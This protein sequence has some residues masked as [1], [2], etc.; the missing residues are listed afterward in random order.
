L[1]TAFKLRFREL[2]VK[3]FIGIYLLRS[4]IV[5]PSSKVAES[6]AKT[7]QWLIDA[8]NKLSTKGNSL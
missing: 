6:K 1:Q 3:K 5:D 7:K 2:L 8:Q 4:K